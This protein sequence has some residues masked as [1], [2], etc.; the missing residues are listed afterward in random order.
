MA[1][2]LSENLKNFF[3]DCY[4]QAV[5]ETIQDGKLDYRNKKY[6]QPDI[7]S[8]LE[9]LEKVLVK[10]KEELSGD[11]LSV[12]NCYL[13]SLRNTIKNRKITMGATTFISRLTEFIMY[14]CIWLN[15]E[16]GFN[17][18]MKLESR[19]KSLEGELTKILKKS[20]EQVNSNDFII[21]AQPPVI[22][23]RYGLRLIITDND[24]Q[25]LLE[26]TRIIV[27]ILTNPVSDFHLEFTKWIKN[28]NYKFGGE[29]IPKNKLLNLMEYSFSLSD[30]KDYVNNPRKS[31]YQS[32]QG[33]ISIDA[34]SPSLGGL[35]FELQVRT[36]EMHI[37]AE[38]GPASHDKYKENVA[39]Y[40]DIFKIEDY[41]GGIVF[42]NGPDCLALDKDGLSTHAHILSRHVSPHV[43]ER[44]SL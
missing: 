30:V 5:K 40:Q 25:L 41:S 37:N 11:E 2:K 7:L 8:I 1:I 24:P 6:R 13:P 4:N 21:A 38:S 12:L 27:S 17:I 20:L 29:E 16:K 18:D 34:T 26:V 36:W 9:H 22:R 43:I 42:Y 33:T 35:K 31:T 15:S 32:W 39:E 3:H 44:T 28:A 14:V 10:R 23:D 19:R